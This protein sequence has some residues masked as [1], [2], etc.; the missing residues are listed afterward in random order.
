V[1]EA[2]RA[3]TGELVISFEAMPNQNYRLLQVGNIGATDWREIRTITAAPSGRLETLRLPVPSDD[4]RFF[5]LE[6]FR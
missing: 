2:T 6:T 1:L 5:R 4:E 3:S